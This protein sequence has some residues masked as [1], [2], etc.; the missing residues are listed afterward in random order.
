MKKT[1]LIIVSTV[2]IMGVV[3]FAGVGFYS[4]KFSANSTFGTVDVSN[5]TLSEA[6]AK[7]IEDLNDKEFVLE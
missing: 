2:L 4:E 3:Y 5:L 1:L 7:V 6:Q